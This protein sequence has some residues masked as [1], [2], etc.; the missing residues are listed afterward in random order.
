MGTSFFCMTVVA[1][2]IHFVR[3][4]HLLAKTSVVIVAVRAFH[5]P[6]SYGMVGLLVFL[7]SYAPMADIAEVGLGG[8]QILPRAGM[9]RMAVVTRNTLGLVLTYVP[10]GQVFLFTVTG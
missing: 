10:E 1:E 8:F 2:F 4:D 9:N 3:L 6:F 7:G 5:F